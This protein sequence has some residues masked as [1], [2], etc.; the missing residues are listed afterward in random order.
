VFVDGRTAKL[1][2]LATRKPA[3]HSAMESMYKEADTFYGLL[4][5]NWF[6]CNVEKILENN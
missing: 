3:D 2:G 1:N 5:N 4:P 6:T